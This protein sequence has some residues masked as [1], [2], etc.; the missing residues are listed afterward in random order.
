VKASQ[1]LSI[2]AEPVNDRIIR[3]LIKACKNLGAKSD[4][5]VTICS[6]GETLEDEFIL[7]ELRHWNSFDAI[8]SETGR[9][10]ISG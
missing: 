10:E 5:L 3:E 6:Y 8:R 2:A 7:S 9:D 4:L 1:E